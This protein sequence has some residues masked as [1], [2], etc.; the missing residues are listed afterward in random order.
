MRNNIKSKVLL[1]IMGVIFVSSCQNESVEPVGNITK[2]YGDS[3]AARAA[4]NELYT[5]GLSQLYLSTDQDN[6]IPLA[7]GSYLSGLFES[8]ATQGRTGKTYR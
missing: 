6:G 5:K 8:E 4:V 2:T 7:W 1:L 3:I